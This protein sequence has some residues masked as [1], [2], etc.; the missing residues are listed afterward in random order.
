MQTQEPGGD[1][2]DVNLLWIERRKCLLLVHAR[3]LCSVF[4]ADVRKTDLLAVG[5][6]VVKLIQRERLNEE[7]PPNTFGH[8]EADAV[9]LAKTA[10]RSVLGYMNE[11]A[12]CWRV[13][14]GWRGRDPMLRHRDAQ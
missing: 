3:A 1:D 8:L 10:S 4:A 5:P 13:H 14:R 12:R 6:A 9:V 2:W 11:M 7:L